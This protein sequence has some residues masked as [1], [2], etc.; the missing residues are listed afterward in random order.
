VSTE[1]PTRI[2]DPTSDASPRLRELFDAGREELPAPEQL[3][4]LAAR[5]GPLLGPGGGGGG[6]GSGGGGGGGGGVLPAKLGAGLAAGTKV[7]I[8]IAALAAAGAV[9]WTV[10]PHGGD[11]RHA[12]TDLPASA[13][14][15][16]LPPVRAPTGPAAPDAPAGPVLEARPTEPAPAPAHAAIRAT[17]PRNAL[18]TGARPPVVPEAVLPADPAT[19]MSLLDR[20]QR[21]VRSDPARALALAD[22]HARGYPSGTLAQEREVIAIDAL[23]RLG[24]RDEAVARGARFHAA[25]PGSSHGRR[26]DVLIAAP[27]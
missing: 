11:P 13:P 9:V 12:T 25:F 3:S 23:V 22:E 8:A 18:P 15:S 17:P 5:L 26:I 21:A 6:G 16:A 10:V 7:G 20:A 2:V 27:P 1:D 4:S 14:A 24:R 19:E